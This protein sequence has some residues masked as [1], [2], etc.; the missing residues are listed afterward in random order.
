M[1]REFKMLIYLIA[2][3]NKPQAA[4]LAAKVADLLVGQ[5]V[6]VAAPPP[7]AAILAG[8]GVEPAA[9][10]QIAG[11]IS[12]AIAL[13][14]D[15]TLIRTAKQLLPFQI[16]LLGINAGRLGF[17]A[18]LEADEL[19]RLTALTA[20]EY[21]IERRMLLSL[22]LQKASGNAESYTAFNDI[23]ISR[24]ALSRI[25]D[26]TVFCD[27]HFVGSYRADGIL[28]ATPTGSTAY[29]LSAGGPIVDPSIDGIIMTPI[30]PH[31]LLS[32]TVM[33]D[34]SHRLKISVGDVRKKECFITVDGHLG[35]PVGENDVLLIEKSPLT[36]PLI[37]LGKHNFYEII[38]D[39]FI[40]R[41][42]EMSSNPKEEER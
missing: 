20:G 21:Q 27:D 8:H 12:Y 24:G 11:E 26:V 38:K 14:G 16:P 33:F 9:L 15:G 23:V 34:V 13:G 3:L 6:R 40:D 36:V 31:S 39:K 7:L 17:L 42:G 5:K 32:R 1:G 41:A 30:C 10:P 22:T 25:V 28:F 2:N 37:H 4:E 19:E 29:S 18:G 35:I